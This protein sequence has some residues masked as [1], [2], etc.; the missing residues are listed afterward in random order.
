MEE[1]PG[2]ILVSVMKQAVESAPLI[3]RQAG[4]PSS[5]RSGTI[6][7][8]SS[9]KSRPSRVSFLRQIRMVINS[10]KLARPG[11]ARFL[12]ADARGGIIGVSC[13]YEGVPESDQSSY[14]N[15]E[16]GGDGGTGQ[17]VVNDVLN[18][19][20]GADIVVLAKRVPKPVQTSS[21]TGS[22]T[23][24]AASSAA[25]IAVHRIM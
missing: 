5:S 21:A 18:H 11:S 10:A 23:M 4:D 25:Q 6:D 9:T 7:H 1:T 12:S 24:A 16:T 15:L 22:S 17:S 2:A 14:P 13:T 8:R 20:I 3:T 19:D